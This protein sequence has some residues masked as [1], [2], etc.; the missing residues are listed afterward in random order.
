MRRQVFRVLPIVAVTLALAAAAGT[1]LAVEIE[2][3]K[4]GTPAQG[5]HGAAVSTL[6]PLNMPSNAPSRLFWISRIPPGIGLANYRAT[7]SSNRNTSCS[8]SS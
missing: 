6:A 1:V 8:C 5:D 3:G 2:G 7:A 4:A